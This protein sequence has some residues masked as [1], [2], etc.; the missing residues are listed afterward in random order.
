VKK[1]L[2]RGERENVYRNE[3]KTQ[4]EYFFEGDEPYPMATVTEPPEWAIS[5]RESYSC[6]NDSDLGAT[7]FHTMMD[8]TEL[9]P[10]T[11]DNTL[12]YSL[13]HI[14]Q[15]PWAI[16]RSLPG[17]L[18]Y[19]KATME[20]F[21][22]LGNG[23]LYVYP[24]MLKTNPPSLWAYYLTLPAWCRN[25]PVIYNIVHAFEYRQPFLDIRSKELAMNLACSYL[26]PIEGRLRDVIIEVA[27]SKK[28]RLNMEIGKQMMQES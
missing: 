6:T 3:V 19:D 23:T 2:I 17:L 8:I 21:K 24:T 4:M 5:N 9:A 16:F 15:E 27:S 10:Q 1:K 28:I 20:F 25:H 26:R 11:I 14:E 18:R 12:T 13:Y 7:T 22:G